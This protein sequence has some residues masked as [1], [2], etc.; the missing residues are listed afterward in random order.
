MLVGHVGSDFLV[1]YSDILYN[2]RD[3]GIVVAILLYGRQTDTVRQSQTEAETGTTAFSSKPG[4]T[5]YSVY[6]TYTAIFTLGLCLCSPRRLWQAHHVWK[7]YAQITKR[8]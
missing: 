4:H 2:S 6:K 3:T 8:C 1:H 7:N 5:T